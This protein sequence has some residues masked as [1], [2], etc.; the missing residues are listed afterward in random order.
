VP[1]SNAEIAFECGLLRASNGD[2]D[3]LEF[4]ESPISHKWTFK[5]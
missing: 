5:I 1:S 2:I 4:L 3:H